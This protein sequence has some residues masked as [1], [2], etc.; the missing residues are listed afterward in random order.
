MSYCLYTACL[1]HRETALSWWPSDTHHS[2]SFTVEHFVYIHDNVV[3]YIGQDVDHCD[4]GHGNRDGQRQIPI[5]ENEK[6]GQKVVA[7]MQT[8]SAERHV[9]LRNLQLISNQL[10]KARAPEKKNNP[11]YE[12]PHPSLPLWVFDLFSDEVECVPPRIGVQCWIKGQRHVTSIQ[13]GAFEWVLKVLVK[14]CINF[15]QMWLN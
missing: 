12:M 3:S 7:V 8:I 6:R 14:T 9:H 13:L 2:N 11:A 10:G 5:K 4:N 1:M 15:I